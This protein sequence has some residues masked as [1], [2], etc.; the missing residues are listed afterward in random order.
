MN[1]KWIRI[2]RGF[3]VTQMNHWALFPLSL[4]AKGFTGCVEPRIWLWLGVGILPFLFF[5]LRER[6]RRFPALVVCHGAVAA[7]LIC[8][9]PGWTGSDDRWI[10]VTA[11]VGYAVY[12][13]VYRLLR[14]DIQDEK[15]AMPL[16]VGISAVS[17]L[18]IRYQGYLEWDSY[19]VLS[20][21]AVFA[22]YFL[23]AYLERYL[24][25]LAVNESST[26]HIP[27]REIFSSGGRLTALYVAFITLALLLSSGVGWLRAILTILREV[28]FAILR[29][30]LAGRLQGEVGE[31]I[32]D[33]GLSDGGG[34]DGFELPEP[35]EPAFFWTVL[36]YVAV[37]AFC[38]AALY[39][40]VRILRILPSLI[41]DRMGKRRVFRTA[42]AESNVREVREKCRI[43]RKQRAVERRNPFAFASPEE[44][45]RRL[46]RKCILNSRKMSGSSEE[47]SQSGESFTAREWGARLER[48]GLARPYEKARYSGESCTVED[49]RLM[50]EACR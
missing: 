17:L 47:A 13:V 34:N 43:E 37:I 18:L 4:F 31:L 49:I 14:E 33:D 23:S 48:P 26:G 5:L 16:V 30:L 46:Y 50:K 10:Y 9:L 32:P 1:R 35:G 42:S 24:D 2:A 44:R 39:L 15:F 45:I 36:T 27:E 22:L 28:V 6:L 29:F 3:L 20:L 7:A 8:C 21:I 12:S 19:Y 41:R 40:L 38:A 25:F 11:A